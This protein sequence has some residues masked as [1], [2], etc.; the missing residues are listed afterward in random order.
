[1]NSETKQVKE[2]PGKIHRQYNYSLCRS[3]CSVCPYRQGLLKLLDHAV[4]IV[5]TLPGRENA[6]PVPIEEI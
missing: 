4:K 3:S 5:P 1:M 6:K 2:I